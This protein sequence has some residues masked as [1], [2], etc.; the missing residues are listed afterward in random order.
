M[1]RANGSACSDK[2]H[3]L[4]PFD[5]LLSHV[6]FGLALSVQSIMEPSFDILLAISLNTHIS[7]VAIYVFISLKAT[8]YRH[9]YAFGCND[10]LVAAGMTSDLSL[11]LVMSQHLFMLVERTLFLECQTSVVSGVDHCD[12]K[13]ST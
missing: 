7:P 2:H 10:F 13:T 1:M 11:L 12:R 4:S 8:I 6:Q 3:S 5:D 9:R